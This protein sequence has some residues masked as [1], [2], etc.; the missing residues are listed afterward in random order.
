MLLYSCI[1]FLSEIIKM[2]IRHVH[3]VTCSAYIYNDI[4]LLIIVYMD[5]LYLII[6]LDKDKLT[7]V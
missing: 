4:K 3:L 2:L 6:N 1:F 5:V 7:N